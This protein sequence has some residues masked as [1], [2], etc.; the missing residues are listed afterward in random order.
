MQGPKAWEEGEEARLCR[1]H[2]DPPEGA[3]LLRRGTN[4]LALLVDRLVE[5]VRLCAQEH[6]VH[7]RDVPQRTPG[8]GDGGHHLEGAA[9]PVE[10]VP[11][12]APGRVLDALEDRERFLDVLIE[13]DDELADVA[14]LGVVLGGA[15]AQLPAVRVLPAAGRKGRNERERMRGIT[16]EYVC[17]R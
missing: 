17:V 1:A 7:A 4:A 9:A 12:L 15:L 3:R 5:L 13:D 16:Q 14:V 10:L 8:A 6:A 11:N 2:R